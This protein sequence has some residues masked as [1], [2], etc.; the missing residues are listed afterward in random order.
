MSTPKKLYY[1]E[2][3]GIFH[4]LLL[5]KEECPDIAEYILGDVVEKSE[6]H[7]SHLLK[8][9]NGKIAQLESKLLKLADYEDI[10]SQS[11]NKTILLLE[12][13][14]A[15]LAAIPFCKKLLVA[16]TQPQPLDEFCSIDRSIK[17]DDFPFFTTMCEVVK[18]L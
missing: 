5:P 7:S 8:V 4:L 17:P 16:N 18:K 6:A 12:C 10:K 15:I 3:T 2:S 1:S 13:K 11:N 9:A 14:E